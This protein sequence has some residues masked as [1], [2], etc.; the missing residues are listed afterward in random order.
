MKQRTRWT[1]KRHAG[2]LLISFSLFLFLLINF[3]LLKSDSRWDGKRRLTLAIQTIGETIPNQNKPLVIFSLEPQEDN[4]TYF[5]L[6]QNTLLDVPFGYKIYLAS[7]VY[8]LGELENGKKGGL[9]LSKSI[10]STLGVAIDA[11]LVVKNHS[12]VLPESKE[13]IK[14]FKSTYF[15]LIKGILLL[16]KLL[17]TPKTIE[18]NLSTLDRWRL[19]NAIRSLR[20]DQIDFRDLG[21]TDALQDSQLADKTPVKTIEK[22]LFDAVTSD[23]FQDTAVRRDNITLEVVNAT[24]REREAWAFS[25]ILEHMGG[26]V[27][28]K[29]T[30]KKSSSETCLL[31]Y[32]SPS[33]DAT[34]IALRLK[35]LYSCVKK[36]SIDN[37]ES[38]ADIKIV[39]GE[40]FVK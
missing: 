36:D 39:L 19:W 24:E 40:G 21:Q 2:W 12:L 5:T 7:S 3:L 17:A 10:E 6:P 27:I 29:T 33:L 34:A 32:S 28:A 22:E 8:N 15:T 23:S 35:Q 20:A 4:A 1:N 9:L 25:R 26:N 18:T 11:Y 16:P 38:L 30:A 14:K 13:S 31:Y 37:E